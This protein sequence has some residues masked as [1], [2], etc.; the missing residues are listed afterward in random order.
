MIV[1]S[2][3]NFGNILD[4]DGNA[5]INPDVGVKCVDPE[6]QTPKIDWPIQIVD[7]NNQSPEFEAFDKVINVDLDTW[8]SGSVINT[9]P[10]LVKDQD[11][12]QEYGEIK[13]AGASWRDGETEIV[14]VQ[15]GELSQSSPWVTPLNL[16][17]AN[18]KIEV[19]NYTIRLEALDMADNRAEVEIYVNVFRGDKNFGS[20]IYGSFTTSIFLAF[21]ALW[22]TNWW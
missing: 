20:S 11:K 14:K 8:K 18:D 22:N 13:S 16:Y 12:T 6:G 1:Q 10:I 3:A 5:T 21:V 9:K 19:R 7:T 17:L 15:T 2:K 4:I